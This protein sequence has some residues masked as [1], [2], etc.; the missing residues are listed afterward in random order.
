MVRHLFQPRAV[1]FVLASSLAVVVAMV[2][3]LPFRAELIV[4]RWRREIETASDRVAAEKVRQLALAGPTSMPLLA[5]LVNST[6]P[7]IADSAADALRF[8]VEEMAR[9]PGDQVAV[10]AQLL[11]DSLA[12]HVESYGP[13]GKALAADLARQAIRLPFEPG[14]VD[15]SAFSQNCRKV[16]L[17]TA[18]EQ[19]RAAQPVE[20][21]AA[22]REKPA[23]AMDI[24]EAL[25]RPEDVDSLLQ[26]ADLP[27][28]GLP[29]QSPPPPRVAVRPTPP[30][31]PE[32]IEPAPFPLQPV[33]IQDGPPRP[34]YFHRAPQLERLEPDAPAGREARRPRS[35]PPLRDSA[36]Q[37]MGGRQ[38][39]Q[40]SITAVSFVDLPVEQVI[41]GLADRNEQVA[42]AAR[43]ELQQRGFRA[44]ELAIAEHLATGDKQQRLQ[45]VEQLPRL[46]GVDS[47][48]WLLQLGKDAEAD[49]R[50]AALSS[51]A[52]AGDPEM[53]DRVIDLARTDS[54]PRI[55]RLAEQIRQLRR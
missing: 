3:V 43:R 34:E 27:G 12:E 15:L 39:T 30:P 21:D 13:A 24:A 17:A 51:L 37:T 20:H 28:G 10:E 54:D 52:S 47:R 19:Q 16:F 1:V 7:G 26:V 49:I 44:E 55:V 32:Q 42:L 48:P 33:K 45:L 25:G 38:T 9:L 2:F 36:A 35:V 41:D 40:Q 11:V 22:R 29:V 4:D 31:T 5:E 6:R 50:L 53:V 46:S 8:R 23:P 18:V 14:K